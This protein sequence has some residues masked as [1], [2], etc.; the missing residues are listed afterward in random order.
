VMISALAPGLIA[1][2][3]CL[4][5]LP[6]LQ[7]SS[8]MAR[9]LMAGIS[10]VLLVRYFVWRVTQTLPPPGFTADCF[11]G[12]PFALAEAASLAAVCLSLL[13]L[14]RTIDRSVEVT[15]AVRRGT[16]AAPAPLI[17]VFICTYNE[18]K[19][20]LE[21]TI[22]G[23]TGLDYG[24][25]RVW[26][27]D[28][29]RR[30]WLKRLTED[31]GCRYLTRPDNRHAKAG[32]INHALQ[33]VAGLRERPEF[34]SILDAD[35]VPMP[36]FL[37]RTTTLME[38]KTVGVVQTPQHFINPDPIQS[39]LAAAEVWPDEQRFFFDIL[40]PAKDAWGV[41]FCCGTSSVIRFSSLMQIGGFPTDS[42]TE[43]Y[44]VTLRLKELGYRTVYLNE[45]L[46]LGLAPEGLKEYITQRGRWCLGLMQI[47]RGRSGPL[48]LNSKLSFIDRLSLVDAFMSWAAVYGTKVFGLVVPWL[49]LLL[50]IKAVHA[51]LFE[52]LKYFLPFYVWHAF[53][54]AWI[55]RGRSL[56]I[57]TD[58]SQYIA[59]PAVLKAV[60]TGLI[61]PQG[62]KFK[63]TAKGG[64]RSQRFI[65][66]PLLRIYGSALLITLLAIAYA[67]ILNLQGENIAYGGLALA[68]SLYNGVI[69]AIVC[70]ICIEQPR[71]RKAERFQRDEP[72]L[73]HEGGTS[74]LV[75]MADISITGARFVDP[76]PPPV[77]TILNCNV[78]GQNVSAIVARR[79]GD[80]FGVRFEETVATRVR[81]VRAFYAGEYARA[82][83][84]VRAAPVG[85]A[86]L[87]RLFN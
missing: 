33:H 9:S 8:T 56:A 80:G 36:D 31:L 11:V 76:A 35:F 32:N 60:I 29:G 70:F 48:S 54:M 17:D 68:W 27:L 63:V 52:L 23:A 6:L 20:I 85:K 49:Y 14:S 71:R 66:W 53:T 74:R 7:R 51:D 39:N 50:G 22:I 42:V 69:L 65:E 61:R 73:I 47:V 5:I 13:F 1:F 45:R 10:F 15:A 59:A 75:R 64:D 46:T 2:G 78:Y 18:E 58:L 12:Y 77:R 72:V 28:D 24:N 87:L 82:F 34:I 86:L 26:I 19:A 67:F 21:R 55:S 4:V 41:A 40:M 57:M 43:D 79:T 81:V 25:Y 3:S 44:L 62:H 37:T 16:G 83:R 30:L 38:D 84:S